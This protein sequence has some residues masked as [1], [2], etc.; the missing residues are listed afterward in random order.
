MNK[1]LRRQ[2]VVREIASRTQYI[3]KDIMVIIETLMDVIWDSA[4][5]GDCV[6]LKYLQVSGRY[7][8]PTRYYNLKTK[9]ITVHKSHLNL[10]AEIG[11]G[12]KNKFKEEAIRKQTW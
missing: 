7:S 4:L 10:C 11:K 9:T 3:Q 5:D 1:I 8:K 2:D 12:F 6:K